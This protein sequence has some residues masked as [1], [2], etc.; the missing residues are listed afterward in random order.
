MHAYLAGVQSTC[1]VEGPACV[2]PAEIVDTVKDRAVVTDVEA[3][4]R[5]RPFL[6]GIGRNS[7]CQE[8]GV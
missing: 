5:V 8:Q 6:D 1:A 4:K 3:C 2:H 7:V